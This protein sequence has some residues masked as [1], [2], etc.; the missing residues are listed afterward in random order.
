MTIA[1]TIGPDKAESASWLGRVGDAAGGV[2]KGVF[3][4]I[5][6]I[7]AGSAGT[8]LGILI[9]RDTAKGQDQ[10]WI[11]N[12][13]AEQRG[14]ATDTASTLPP[15]GASQAAAAAAAVPG[16]I[17]PPTPPAPVDGIVVASKTGE[18]YYL[19]TCASAKRITPE[20]LV[21]FA[22]RAEA[23]AAGYRAAKNCKGL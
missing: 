12:L 20:K 19:P 3:V 1:D 8:G 15:A 21:T 16:Y 6:L 17:P 18:V 7:L 13:P 4:V 2:P 11:E 9:G 5:A 22:S 14:I 23:E 10:F